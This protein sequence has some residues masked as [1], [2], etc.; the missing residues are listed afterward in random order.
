MDTRK[1]G[2][3]VGGRLR[4][5]GSFHGVAVGPLIT[6]VEWHDRLGTGN[7]E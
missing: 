6:V 3:R 1:Y 4:N 2:G 7:L 5:L